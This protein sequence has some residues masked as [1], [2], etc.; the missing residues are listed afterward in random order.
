MPSL[1]DAVRALD[2]LSRAAER[3]PMRWM[4]WLPSQLRVFRSSRRVRLFRAGNQALG[5]TT[6]GLAEVIWCATGRH[7]YR[8]VPQR[9]GT[10]WV[11]CA[12]WSQSVAIQ[13]K[14]WRLLPK[15]LMHPSTVFD[16]AGGFQGKHPKVK[17]RGP[18]GDYSVIEF[19]TTHQGTLSLAGASIDG[20][21]FDEPPKSSA[22]YS[23]VS[24]RV[25]ARGGW[26][27]LSLTPVGAPV[28]W[29]REA[30]DAG[31]VEDIHAPLTPEQLIPDGMTEP[32]V[33]EDGRPRDQQWIDD[34]I[35][36]T[37]PH[38]VPV[39]IHGEW[40]MR[41]AARYFTTFVSSGPGSHVT[42]AVP[43]VDMEPLIGIDHGHRPGKQVAYLVGVWRREDGP[44]VAVLDEYCD[45]VGTASPEDDAR[46]VLAMLE[47]QG[48]TW[49]RDLKAANGDRVH[50]PGKEGK[51]S[52]R[53]LQAHIARVLRVAPDALSPRIDTSKHGEGRG[54]GSVEVGEKWLFHLMGRPGAFSVH[55]RCK[56]LIDALDKYTMADDDYKDPIDALRYALA[57]F[58]FARVQRAQ[59]PAL[60]MG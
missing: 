8:E 15:D 31:Q 46:G 26:V 56:R 48:W 38:E 20:A 16:E 49:Q 39:R 52:N 30:V 34:V 41:L 11:I 51:K 57:P 3:E 32:I 13:R 42:R 21:L 33:G 14:L 35:A 44:C 59:A 60:V 37:L 50:M 47:R 43:D 29:L 58:I 2:E 54:R 25:L 53:D 45:E 5:K 19:K 10:Y 17:V 12:S 36:S 18:D 55:P 4:R 27:L 24:K 22:L 7:P 23:E 1:L 28:D 9:H 40:E 6:C